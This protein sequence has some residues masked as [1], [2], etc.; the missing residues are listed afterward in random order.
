MIRNLL[1]GML[2]LAVTPIASP[3]VAL[4][5][6][7]YDVT[8]EF[9][10]EFNSAFIAYWKGRTGETVT[11]NQSHGGS[12]KQARSVV[13]GLDAAAV[14]MNQSNDIDLFTVDEVFGGWKQVQAVHF[15]D[16][17]LFDQIYQVK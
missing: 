17:G 14:T 6:F 1:T 7:S 2:L 15:N 5:N 12:S 3:D 4:L 8:C 13:D 9:Y 11:I 16:G 10:R